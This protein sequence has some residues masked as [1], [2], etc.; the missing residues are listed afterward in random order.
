MK[1]QKAMFE[2]RFTPALSLLNELLNFAD[3][4]SSYI[5]GRDSYE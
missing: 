3:K 2:M 5:S 4:F 1:L